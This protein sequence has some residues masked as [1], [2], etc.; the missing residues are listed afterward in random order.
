MIRLFI[1]RM[2]CTRRERIKSTLLPVWTEVCSSLLER[3]Q[4]VNGRKEDIQIGSLS[5]DN[6]WKNQDNSYRFFSL[7]FSNDIFSCNPEKF[8][9]SN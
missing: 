7:I 8:L 4:P 5:A 1:I 6:N 9:H 2:Y 3:K